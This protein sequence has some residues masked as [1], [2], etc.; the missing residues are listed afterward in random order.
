MSGDT[1]AWGS[2]QDPYRIHQERYISVEG[3]P[4]KLVRDGGVENLRPAT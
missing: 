2:H 4:R 1:L 3:L